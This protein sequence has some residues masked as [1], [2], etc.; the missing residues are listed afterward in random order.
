MVQCD[1]GALVAEE[2]GPTHAYLH[3]EPGCWR[4]FGELQLR[5]AERG[6]DAGLAVDA[7]AAQ[8]PGR[9]EVERRQ[10]QSVAVHLI[11][12]HLRFERG[13]TAGRL[14]R[15]RGRCSA[16]VLPLLG[17]DDWPALEPPAEWGA[18]TA[19]SLLALPDGEL[20]DAVERWAAEVWEA[21][22]PHHALVRGWAGLL[23][24]GRAE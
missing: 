6:I 15:Y 1:C 21:W 11:A 5:L 8:H 4:A 10:R 19:P 3:A 16:T 7:Y 23:L 9:A 18:R 14:M 24:E 13:V 12:L 17:A 20:A 22:A 2:A